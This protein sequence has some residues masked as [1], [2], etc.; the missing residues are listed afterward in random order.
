MAAAHKNIAIVFS[1][2][3][4]KRYGKQHGAK[5]IIRLNGPHT[6]PVRCE[7]LPEAIKQK[8]VSITT[9]KKQQ[10]KNTQQMLVKV[11]AVRKMAGHFC[12]FLGKARVVPALAR[13]RLF[14]ANF[15]VCHL[16][17][18][19]CF[20]PVVFLFQIFDAFQMRILLCVS[21]SAVLH[22]PGLCFTL[23]RGRQGARGPTAIRFA[24]GKNRLGCRPHIHLRHMPAQCRNI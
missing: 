6:R 9:P 4:L 12:G 11:Y 10:I 2:Q 14:P 3:A 24:S 15:K 16:L 1:A 7:I 19:A 18:K 23:A 5:A 22:I 21:A 17:F 8:T 13:Q 20:P